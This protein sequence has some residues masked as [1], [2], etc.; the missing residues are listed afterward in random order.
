M[1]EVTLRDVLNAINT[2][3]VSGQAAAGTSSNTIK[4]AIGATGSVQTI[5]VGS[6]NVAGPLP[7]LIHQAF[8]D[9]WSQGGASYSGPPL[10]VLNGASAGGIANGLELDAGSDNSV[11]RGLV[12]QQFANNGVELNGSNGDQIT[13][14]DI[15]TD[16]TGTAVLSNGHDGVLIDHGA[17]NNTVSG[18]VIAGAVVTPSITTGTQAGIFTLD[19]V[20]ISGNLASFK[21]ELHYKDTPT[22]QMVFLDVDVSQSS[23]ALIT[24]PTTHATDFS[25]FSFT[26]SSTLTSL[27]AIPNPPAGQ[28]EYQTSPGTGLAP[29]A[30]YTLGTVTYDVSKFG[31]TPNSSLVVS[32]AGINTAIGVEQNGL[33]ATFGFAPAFFLVGQQPLQAATGIAGVEIKDAGTTGNT[34]AG[35]LIGTNKTGTATLGHLTDGVLLDSGAANNVVGGTTAASGNVIGGNDNGVALTDSGTTANLVEGNHVGTDLGGTINLGNVVSGVLLA[36]GASSNTVGSTS[37]QG[38][39][40]I[41]FNGKGVVVGS[42]ATD[43][44]TK[45][46]SILGNSIVNNTG[47]GIDLGNQGMPGNGNGNATLPNSGQATPLLTLLTLNSIGGTLTATANTNFHL[48]FFAT[49]V[50]TPPNQGQQILGSANVMVGATGTVKFTAPVTTIPL[51]NVVTATATNL[52]TGDTSEFSP[53]GTQ[54]LVLSSPAVQSSSTTQQ[55]TLSA[56][57]LSKTGPITTGQVT[58][59]IAGLPGA[60]I[61]TP[62]AKGIVTVNFPVPANTPSGQYTVSATF[63]GTDSVPGA[64]STSVQTVIAPPPPPAPPPL[65]PARIGRRWNR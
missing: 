23:S 58:F 26:P 9:G 6:G 37:A 3:A 34:V 59:T 1:G 56:Q 41:D 65:P 31:I 40:V 21:L 27:G 35:N 36:G 15:G 55:A 10:I 14:N 28:F 62:N 51:N 17:T 50:G 18:N 53:V 48:E 64:T 57:L 29:N 24:N 16:Q 22:N 39:N 7:A 44:A 30:T 19:P 60:V 43:T 42:T 2:Q 61:G 32:I 12:L 49:P 20:S 46:D 52:T 13:G 45:G 4:F 38:G 63:P 5:K 33:P 8:L 47:L 25:A 11:V 54:L